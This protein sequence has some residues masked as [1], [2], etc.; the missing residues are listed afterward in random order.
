MI[1]RLFSLRASFILF[2]LVLNIAAFVVIYGQGIIWERFKIE[3]E[4]TQ[5]D[6]PSDVQANEGWVC[7]DNQTYWR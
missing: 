6:V 5:I 3:N 4:C 1:D 7:N 2:L